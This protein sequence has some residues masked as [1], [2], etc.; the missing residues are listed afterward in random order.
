MLIQA[1]RIGSASTPSDT[2]AQQVRERTSEVESPNRS[3]P[4]IASTT[5]A[6]RGDQRALR[7]GLGRDVDVG[8][9]RRRSPPTRERPRSRPAGPAPARRRRAT[10]ARAG[11]AARATRPRPSVRPDLCA[12]TEQR[13]APSAA[14][15][16]GTRPI[17]AHASTCTSTPRSRARRTHLGGGLQRADLVVGELRTD[18]RGVGRGCA[19]T[20][21]AA[22][23]R[24]S[25]STPHDRA[26]DAGP[27]DRVT[28]ARVLDRGRDDV[29]ATARARQAAPDRR[30]HG[31]GARRR[32]HDLARPRT[33]ERRDLL[34]RVLERDAR[35]AAFRVQPAGIGGMVARGTGASRRARP[36]A[37]ER[38][39]R[40]RGTPRCQH[41]RVTQCA[42]PPGRLCSMI[43]CVS[44]YSPSSMPLIIP[45]STAHNTC[46]YLLAA[47]PNGQCSATSVSDVPCDSG[48]RRTRAPSARRQPTRPRP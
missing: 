46:G 31:L 28:H 9:R 43:G 40:D 22:S 7:V 24:P 5:F 20:T 45:V 47:S 33:D 44:P 32:E 16:N 34:T 21:A 18:E 37:A 26:F 10:A 30:V 17:A 23:N 4:G 14:K 6:A 27:F 29:T 42:S 25:P 35:H 36:A 13:S 39:T 19:S 12:V 48:A 38:T 1:S 11:P 15:S 8:R 2:D 3:T 41:S